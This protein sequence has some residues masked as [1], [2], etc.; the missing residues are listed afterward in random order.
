MQGAE[1]QVAG[2]R[3]AQRRLDGFQ[4]A[5]FAD[6]HH[7]RVFAQGGAQRVGERLG[8]GVHSRW[9]TRQFL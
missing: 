7:V 1:G 4:V 9:F 3:N 8:I 5:H 6:Q 2:F